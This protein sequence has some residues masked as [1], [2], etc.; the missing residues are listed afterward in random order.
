MWKQILDWFKHLFTLSQQ[1]QQNRADIKELRQEMTSFAE[2][3]LRLA[4][5]L[6]NF[7]DTEALERE[8]MALRLENELL[9]F[10]RR[11]L[12]GK[13]EEDRDK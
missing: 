1:T 5:E 12:K 11:M 8:K 6:R 9:R 10:E 3:I 7:K 13:T 2:N 4:Y